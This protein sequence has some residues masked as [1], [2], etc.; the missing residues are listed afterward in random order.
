MMECFGMVGV[1]VFVVVKYLQKDPMIFLFVFVA[2]SCDA[3][4]S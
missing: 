3:D 1:S 2:W 4:V